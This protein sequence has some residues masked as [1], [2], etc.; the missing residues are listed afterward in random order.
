M[1]TCLRVMN[2]Q[3]TK[4]VMALEAPAFLIRGHGGL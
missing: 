2:S 4:A 3:D 1:E